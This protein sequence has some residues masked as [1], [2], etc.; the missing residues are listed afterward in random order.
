MAVAPPEEAREHS[1]KGR[2]RDGQA[3]RPKEPGWDDLSLQPME[4]KGEELR[5]SKVE[6]GLSELDLSVE[7][8]GQQ[9]ELVG[10]RQTTALD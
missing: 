6:P 7:L 2:G 3:W 9:P 10:T 1:E 4:Q 5:S 8:L